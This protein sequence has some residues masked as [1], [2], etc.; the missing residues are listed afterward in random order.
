VNIINNEF[1]DILIGGGNHT[2]AIQLLEAPDSVI[3]GNFIH[4]TETGIVAYDSITRATIE[5]NV[6]D[7]Y[8][9][10]PIELYS[11]DS[12]VVRH[13]TLKFGACQFN[14]ECGQILISRKSADDAGHGTVVVDN[15]ATSVEID[16]GSTVGERHHNLLREG[17]AAGDFRGAPTYAGGANPTT[18]LGFRL[19][20]G[21]PGKNAASDGGDVGIR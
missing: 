8:R 10:W 7:I 11:D 12:S 6:L 17:P 13:N 4:G 18:Y 3:R 21:S 2:D 15:V 16:A 19:A 5:N 1:R 9:P 14:L 20:G